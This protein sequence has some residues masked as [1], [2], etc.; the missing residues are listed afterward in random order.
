MHAAFAAMGM[1]P[2]GP[3]LRLYKPITGRLP[4]WPTPRSRFPADARAERRL[5]MRV[6]R[7]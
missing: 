4:C 7:R 5:R 2:P 3:G 6:H 1:V